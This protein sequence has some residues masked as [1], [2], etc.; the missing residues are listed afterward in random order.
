MSAKKRKNFL[1]FKC[2]CC[3]S[4]VSQ[5]DAS[6]HKE[7][8]CP[9]NFQKWIHPFIINNCLFTSIDVFHPQEKSLQLI[10]S[11]EKD[12]FILLPI[13]VL[14]ICKIPI[15]DPILIKTDNNNTPF[16]KSAWP[17]SEKTMNFTVALSNEGTKSFKKIFLHQLIFK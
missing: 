4:I 6:A 5:K 11:D 16:I 12:N 2:D 7:K 13:H 14:Q 17:M 9:P 15:G 1:W 3:N 8:S 10:S